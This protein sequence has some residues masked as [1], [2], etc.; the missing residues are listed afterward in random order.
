MKKDHKTL[1]YTSDKVYLPHQQRVI[2]EKEQLD[3]KLA[4]LSNFIDSDII[5]KVSKEEV[6]LLQAQLVCM[7][8]YS[9]IL[10]QRVNLW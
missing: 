6:T 10:K 5:T 2:E 1:D 8:G 4:K 9:D 3:D 7:K